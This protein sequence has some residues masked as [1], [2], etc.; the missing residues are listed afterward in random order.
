MRFR[1]PFKRFAAANFKVYEE[2]W[3]RISRF[4]WKGVETA[5][6]IG[7]SLMSALNMSSQHY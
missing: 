1:Q 4:L 5:S 7:F 6:R 3:S 2:G